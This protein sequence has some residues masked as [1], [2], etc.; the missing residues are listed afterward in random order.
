[1]QG[2]DLT[3]E[4]IKNLKSKIKG[5]F[6]NPHQFNSYILFN[7][8]KLSKGNSLSISKSD[9]KKELDKKFD[10]NFD[11]MKSNGGHNNGKIFV[12]KNNKIKLNE[13]IASFI[14][15]EYKKRGFKW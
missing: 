15:D 1:M 12:G 2:N 10:G 4:E 5:W 11:S 14:I 6:E 9:L 7:Y 13:D 3:Q 8:M